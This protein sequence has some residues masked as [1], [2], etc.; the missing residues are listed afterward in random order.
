MKT[1]LA[2][3]VLFLLAAGCAI[4]WAIED[5]AS[6]YGPGAIVFAVL[7]VLFALYNRFHN[8]TWFTDSSGGK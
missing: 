5:H 8:G 7:F 2:F 4:G 6:G 3:L 1:S